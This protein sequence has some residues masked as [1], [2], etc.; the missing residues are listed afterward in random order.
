MTLGCSKRELLLDL[1]K[2]RRPVEIVI[3]ALALHTWGRVGVV[4]LRASDAVRVLDCYTEGSVSN[5]ELVA[6]SEA[7]ECRDDI[8][9]EPSYRDWLAQLLFEVSNPE[10]NGEFSPSKALHWKVRL[11]MPSGEI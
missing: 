3:S 11:E 4:E 6:W 5:S 9:L 7:I 8:D 10:I 2:M 1:I